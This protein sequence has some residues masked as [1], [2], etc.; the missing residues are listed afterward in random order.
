MR[1]D[2]HFVVSRMDRFAAQEDPERILAAVAQRC[3]QFAV[4]VLAT[5]GA[6]HG[7]VYNNLL[8]TRLPRLAGLYALFYSDSDHPPQQYQGRLWHWTIGRSA[9]IGMVFSRVRRRQLILPPVEDCG[10]YLDEICAEVAVYDDHHRTIKYSHDPGQCDDSLHALN[11]VVT[12]AHWWLARKRT[13]G[14]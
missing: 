3:E 10:S 12:M 14:A 1:D 7:H 5:D 8:L 13:Y 6:A 9:S 4:R 2:N 11:Y